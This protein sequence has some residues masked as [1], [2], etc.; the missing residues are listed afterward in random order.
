MRCAFEFTVA[1]VFTLLM[2]TS[3]ALAETVKVGCLFPLTGPGGQYGRDS[4]V[5]VQMAQDQLN[6]GQ[7]GA[8]FELEIQIEDSRSK[9]LR[10]VQI[11]RQLVEQAEVDFLCGVV[12]SNVARAVSAEA[13]KKKTFFVGTDHASPSLITDD[14]HPYYFRMNNG[15]RQSML[16]GAKY[17]G[18]HFSDHSTPLKISFIGPDYDYGYQAWD[19]LR[20]FLEQD[21][22]PFEVVGTYWP[23]LFETDYS[24]YLHEL[25][26][27]DV[28][29][30]VSG[31]WGLDLVTF[32]KQARQAELFAHSQFMNFDAG[33]NYEVFAEL[34][35][36]M[37]LGL[38]L[39]ARHHVNWP[40][41]EANRWFVEEFHNRAGRYPSYAA[42][43]AYAGILAIAK[44]VS[45]AGGTR[46]KAALK[47][48]FEALS[49][50]LPEDPVG[51]RSTIDPDTHQILQVQAIGITEFNNSYAPATVQLG[52][53]SVYYPPETW[54]VLETGHAE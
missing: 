10:S 14:L 36:D 1:A 20:A 3:S 17:I 40:E 30:V 27:H 8:A 12:S 9:V 7:F 28:D 18:E 25:L 2:I 43:G 26:K 15:T 33:G 29:I 44:A 34:G 42:Q 16:A 11:A 52:Q 24:V 23:K 19:D 48:A 45:S 49:L 47:K 38:V 50:S 54:P 51:F 41:T 35:N 37:P 4:V 6:A 32:I 21:R 53:W 31:H 5:A 22:I 39:S 46:D 13:A